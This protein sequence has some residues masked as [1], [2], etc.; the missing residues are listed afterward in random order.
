MDLTPPPFLA[1]STSVP[2]GLWSWQGKDAM[3]EGK[4]D[5]ALL[6]S[7]SYCPRPPHMTL[8]R[9]VCVWLVFALSV[10]GYTFWCK[11]V[12]AQVFFLIINAPLSV[13]WAAIKNLFADARCAPSSA[14]RRSLQGGWGSRYP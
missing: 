6:C 9:I 11:C 12:H 4:A 2:E 7:S 5:S 8:C 1:P 13:C 3:A 10:L 14:G